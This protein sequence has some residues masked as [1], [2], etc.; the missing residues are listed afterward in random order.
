MERQI[1]KRP[2]TPKI[3]INVVD[4]YLSWTP[5]PRFIAKYLGARVGLSTRYCLDE[6]LVDAFGEP[7]MRYLAEKRHRPFDETAVSPVATKEELHQAVVDICQPPS[8]ELHKLARDLKPQLLITSGDI[9]IF[10]QPMKE[11]KTG[12]LSVQLRERHQALITVAEEFLS[13]RCRRREYSELR[14]VGCLEYLAETIARSVLQPPFPLLEDEKELLLDIL[15][16]PLTGKEAAPAVLREMAHLFKEIILAYYGRSAYGRRENFTNKE[17]IAAAQGLASLLVRSQPE[18]IMAT[19]QA[20]SSLR[21]EK[22]SV[23][24]WTKKRETSLQ[25]MQTWR[26]VE[27]ILDH[28]QSMPK[29]I[30]RP[31]WEFLGV[32]K[33]QVKVVVDLEHDLITVNADP[34][35]LGDPDNVRKIHEWIALHFFT[36]KEMQIIQKENSVPR[37]SLYR[38]NTSC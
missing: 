1:D 15:S 10:P 28:A 13:L 36:I 34:A 33:D 7:A 6:T 5:V 25:A 11:A 30:R 23:E 29:E 37:N 31:L 24:D 27:G 16:A 22:K 2:E 35:I 19:G 38:H 4:K 32:G 3:V 8:P 17:A 26:E 21:Q 20:I 18:V 9:Q 12:G 14:R